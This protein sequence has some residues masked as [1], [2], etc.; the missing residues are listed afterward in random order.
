MVT[1]A[2]H[3]LSGSLSK[4]S[5]QALM[6]GSRVYTSARPKPVCSPS[7]G[8]LGGMTS[9]APGGVVCHLLDTPRPLALWDCVSSPVEGSSCT[10]LSFS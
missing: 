8:A 9:G 6:R 10:Q 5:G 1:F 2:R 4:C 7:C 3:G